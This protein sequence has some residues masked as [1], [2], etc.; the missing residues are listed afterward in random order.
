M[1]RRVESFQKNTVDA[2]RR[3]PWAEWSD[4][5]IW[6]IRQGEDYDVPTENMR[7]NLHERAKQQVMKVRTEKITDEHGEGLRFCFTRLQLESPTR[8]MLKPINHRGM[9]PWNA[10]TQ[11]TRSF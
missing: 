4:G 3:Y 7:V 10:Q 11:K 1:A 8:R 5:S 9:N 6:E 2:P